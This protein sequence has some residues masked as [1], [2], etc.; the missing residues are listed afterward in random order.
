V[1]L[2]LLV[3]VGLG[4]VCDLALDRLVLQSAPERLRGRVLAVE[5]PILMVAQGV[6]FTV[7]GAVGSLLPV[8]TTIAGAGVLAL[9]VVA[10][11]RPP[12]PEGRS[13]VTSRV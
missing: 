3:A 8:A 1:A 7:W 10:V 12:R 13:A 2:A 4:F 11:L 5:A 6:A 9:V